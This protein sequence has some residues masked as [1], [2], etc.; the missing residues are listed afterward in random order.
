M[1][2]AFI[3]ASPAAAGPWQGAQLL[4]SACPRPM[5]DSG[6]LAHPAEMTAVATAAMSKLRL[7]I[8]TTSRGSHDR[9]HESPA[10]PGGAS[11]GLG[12]HPRRV[13]A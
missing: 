9:E 12:G 4:N 11:L 5:P 10:S 2:G 7:D 3:V 8:F 1:A 13:D 6:A